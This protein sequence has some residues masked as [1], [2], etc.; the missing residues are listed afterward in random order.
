MA[1]QLFHL[2]VCCKEID[3]NVKA[4]DISDSI[5]VCYWVMGSRGSP[6]CQMLRSFQ[7]TK[8]R[9]PGKQITILFHLIIFMCALSYKDCCY[10]YY[11]WST[12]I[13]VYFPE[14]CQW[15]SSNLFHIIFLPHILERTRNRIYVWCNGKIMIFKSLLSHW[16]KFGL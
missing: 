13:Y 12:I 3:P 5:F 9:P 1:L 2:F 11:I 16:I 4:S 14:G 8:S 6:R 7:S 10:M 15:S